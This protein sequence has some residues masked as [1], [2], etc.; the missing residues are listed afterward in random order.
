VVLSDTDEKKWQTALAVAQ[1]ILAGAIAAPPAAPDYEAKSPIRQEQRWL[2]KA[3]VEALIADYKGGLSTYQL[4]SKWG[5]NRHSVSKILTRHGVEQRT[6]GASL[7]EAE[8]T[9]AEALRRDGWSMNAL[10]RKYGIS[11][12]T[13]KKR[14]ELA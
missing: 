2:K 5:L 8:L 13:L 3:E 12:Q 6:Y 9:E 14:L 1:T 10:A 4:A 11:P 7:S